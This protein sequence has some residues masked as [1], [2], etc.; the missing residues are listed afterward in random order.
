MNEMVFSWAEDANGRM[1]HVDSVRRGLNCECSCPNCHEP[2]LARHGDIKAHG[3][4]HHSDTRGAN[5]GI[6]YMV[7]LYKLAEQIIQTKKKIHAPSYYAIFKET[8]LEF[9]DVKIDSHFEREDKQ[10]DVIATSA[11]GKQYILEFTFHYKVLHKQ[12]VDYKNLNCLEIDLCNQTLETVE[13]FL[14]ESNAGRKWLNNQGYFDNIE[15]T[16]GLKGKTVRVVEETE[17]ECC[18]LKSQ[19]CAV[20][21]KKSHLPVVIENSG[22]KFRICKPEEYTKKIEEIKAEQEKQRQIELEEYQRQDEARKEELERKRKRLKEQRL[23]E[24]NTQPLDPSERTCFMCRLNLEWRNRSGSSYA[25]CG[26]YMSM[27]VPKNTPPEAA[28]TCK[29]FQQK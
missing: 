11:D 10:P 3:F 27:R 13:E 29:G 16:Y 18:T 20:R 12:A 26:S 19:C 4:A 1:V 9:V 25:N 22:R 8:D 6:C 7:I 14:L 24:L 17:C 5:L 23:A 28:K 15:Q 2:L 21:S